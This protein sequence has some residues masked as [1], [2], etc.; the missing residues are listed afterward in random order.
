MIRPRIRLPLWAAVALPAA[1]YVVRSLIRG[2]FS[3]DVP[4][5]LLAYGLLAFV[6]AAVA[7]ARSRTRNATDHEPSE[8]VEDRHSETGAERQHDEV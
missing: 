1:A 3:P 4:E 5:D 7:L 6:I 8:K 2:D